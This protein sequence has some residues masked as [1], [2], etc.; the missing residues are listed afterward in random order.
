MDQSFYALRCS[1]RKLEG[2]TDSEDFGVIERVIVGLVGLGP[3][4]PV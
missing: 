2:R 3:A 4:F 1:I